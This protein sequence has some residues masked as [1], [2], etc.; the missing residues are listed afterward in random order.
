L[1]RN[2][3]GNAVIATTQRENKMTTY[4]KKFKDAIKARQ[5]GQTTLY[6]AK[7]NMYYN[8]TAF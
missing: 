8:A 1:S 6:S 4:Y 5:A 7:R 2:K 3:R